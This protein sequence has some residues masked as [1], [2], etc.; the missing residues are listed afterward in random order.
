MKKII[1]LLFIFP[2]CIANAQQ[3]ITFSTAK[4]KTGDNPQWKNASF[5][6]AR[7]KTI[8]TNVVWEEQGYDYN[9]YAWYRFHFKLPSSLKTRSYWKD[10]LRIFLSKIDDVDETFLNGG[11]IGQT[12]SF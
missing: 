11:K 5:N 2:A 7:W 4:F 10:T 12:G 9:G 3:A 1:F 6:D 8:K